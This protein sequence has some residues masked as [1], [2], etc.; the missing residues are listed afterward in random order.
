M[1]TCGN[2]L[3]LN[4]GII[5]LCYSHIIMFMFG[6]LGSGPYGVPDGEFVSDLGDLEYTIKWF[7]SLDDAYEYAHLINKL[8]IF[9]FNV[10]DEMLIDTAP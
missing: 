7:E 9:D 1:F 3:P 2:S 6:D 8:G 10:L 4:W 5:L